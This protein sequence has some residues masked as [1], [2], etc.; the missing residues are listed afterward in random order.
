M[1]E[2]GAI[3]T[4]TL[5]RIL[6]MMAKSDGEIKARGGRGGK[7]GGRGARARHLFASAQL[8]SKKEK[9]EQ[10]ESSSVLD[11]LLLLVDVGGPRLV[12]WWNTTILFGDTAWNEPELTGGWWALGPWRYS[13]R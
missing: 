6:M 8:G 5:M 7:E 3:T 10:K 11:S 12:F 4:I 9:M 2:G 1:K 13:H